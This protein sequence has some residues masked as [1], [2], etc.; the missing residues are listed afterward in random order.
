MTD[1]RGPEMT[2]KKASVLIA[3][4][5]VIAVLFLSR[6]CRQPE[7]QPVV[8]IP[9]RPV[10]YVYISDYDSIFR[11]YA[12][13]V[14]DW[15]LLAAIAYAESRFKD[16]LVSD[17][18]A[19]GLMQIVPRTYERML[20]RMELPDTLE[21]TTELDVRVAVFFM[22]EL[23]K[24]FPFVTDEKERL[25]FVLAS[26]NSGTGHVLDAAR[27]AASHGMDRSSW[28]DVCKVLRRL[29]QEDVYT[30]SVCR[31]GY[32]NAGPTV[33][34]VKFVQSKYKEYCSKELM[35][36]AAEQ[37]KENLYDEIRNNN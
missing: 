9:P 36:R 23:E 32:F 35:F 30:D 29:N 20:K 24:R 13:S 37:L 4:A 10:D 28:N 11:N 5:A 34:Y 14:Y 15:K 12:D 17:M 27:Y 31:N 21:R 6:T 22:H 1:F 26:Y 19:E 18:G 2:W 8:E 16:S 33:H 25:N 3:T 7:E